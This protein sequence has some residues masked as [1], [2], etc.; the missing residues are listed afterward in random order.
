MIYPS[1][2]K[3]DES[4]RM[5]YVALI[6]RLARVM[7]SD[8]AVLV[9]VGYSWNDEHLNACILEALEE[10]P[11]NAAIALM[12]DELDSA[13][14]LVKLAT[15]MP[16]L[17]VSGARSA[18]LGGIEAPWQLREPTNATEAKLLSAW[19]DADALTPDVDDAPVGGVMRLGDF[20]Y[21]SRFVSELNT[22]SPWAN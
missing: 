7:T 8:S 2:L 15:Q 22:T 6:S 18:V 9:T 17:L 10:H 12:Y 21:F 14:H 20:N 5:P 19:F 1:H 16:N 13:P 11:A 3:Y 4:R